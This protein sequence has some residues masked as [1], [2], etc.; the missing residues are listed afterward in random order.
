MYEGN[1]ANALELSLKLDPVIFATITP[2][3]RLISSQMRVSVC[4]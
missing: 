3:K 1:S 2:V 4:L